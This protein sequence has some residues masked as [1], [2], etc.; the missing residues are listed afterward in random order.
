MYKGLLTIAFH[1]LLN[2]Y[3]LSAQ[4]KADSLAQELESATAVSDRARLMNELSWDMKY[5]DVGKSFN[6]ARQAYVIS[7]RSGDTRNL[8]FSCRNLT[9]LC[10]VVSK[11]DSSEYYGKKGLD[12]AI[13]FDYRFEEAKILNLLAILQRNRKN[14]D[15]ALLMH[16]RSM[17]IFK[18]LKNKQEEIGVLNNIGLVYRMMG[19]G[20]SALK[21][22]YDVIETEES[23]NNKTGVA[24]TYSTIADVYSEYGMTDLAIEYYKKSLKL[25]EEIGHKMFMAANLSNLANAY[26]QQGNDS[27]AF[28]FCSRALL[29]NEEMGNL[30]WLGNNYLLMAYIWS[31]SESYSEAKKCLTKAIEYY[32]LVNDNVG[33]CRVNAQMATILTGENQY[34]GAMEYAKR[35][36]EICMECNDLNSLAALHLSAYLSAKKLGN[37]G[38][39]LYFLETYDN[40]RDSL[41]TIED[42]AQVKEL[43]TRYESEK[44]EK[45]NA[46]LKRQSLE[47][48]N[49]IRQQ[50][51]TMYSVIVVMVL[52]AFL[53]L[54]FFTARTRLRKAYNRL[55][56]QKNQIE[57]QREQLE[58]A[59]NKLREL[60]RYKESLTGMIV[61]DLV[62]P[63]GMI[64]SPPD[65]MP[66]NRQI[67][68]MQQAG[69]QMY[70]LVMN[71]LDIQKYEDNA[72]KLDVR[73][74]PLTELFSETK[75]YT[76]F[77]IE[78]KK[79]VLDL[80]IPSDLMV[81]CDYMLISRVFVN[82]LTNAVKFAPAES[83][84]QVSAHKAGSFARIEIHD[85]GIGIPADKIDRI[86][87]KFVQ[88][89]M[90]NS[91]VTRST[92]L[93]LT[94]C[95]L[96]VESN[97]GKIGVISETD[98]GTTFWFTLPLFIL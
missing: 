54:V 85:E 75:S 51:F 11:F 1:I 91:G 76:G 29:V 13:R 60:E 66:E 31:G 69:K 20:A 52:F 73:A 6:Y 87:D 80:Q 19:D 23:V 39:A 47:D 86:F 83:R 61:H 25:C 67:M 22:F 48:E 62:N 78:Q 16:Q 41:N 90:R 79:Q 96:A 71:I 32:T 17:E 10:F 15:Q 34:S 81:K 72:M 8:T 92:G 53:A 12:L 58:T 59:L 38:Q 89:E 26:R 3:W 37:T 14:Y 36:I 21:I 63:L 94:F 95:K 84:I 55:N 2:T 42:R 33:L 88:V 5:S 56:D 46:I 43:Q 57:Q 30:D 45:E 65:T 7:Y 74:C 49:T 93:G 40:L 64:L 98:K 27:L 77:L 44:K 68:L 9:A 70:N 35:G 50:Q 97:G 18:E 82:I 28:V 24:R 4:G